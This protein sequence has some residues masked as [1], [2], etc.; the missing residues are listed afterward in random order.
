LSINDGGEIA[1]FGFDTTGAAHWFVID[2][3]GAFTTFDTSDVRDFASMD[4]NPDGVI[5]GS[6]LDTNLVFHSFRR[7]PDGTLTAIDVPGAGTGTLQGTNATSI[8][9][10]GVITGSYTDAN[11]VSHGFLF[12]PQ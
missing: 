2:Y 12:Q 5:V 3:R 10:T 9:P 4:I 8:N 6:Y 11:G 1:G 7:A